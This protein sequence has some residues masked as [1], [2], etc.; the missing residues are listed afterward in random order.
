MF[1]P[2]QLSNPIFASSTLPIVK[3]LSLLFTVF[4]YAITNVFADHKTDS[5]K[6]ALANTKQ[7]TD[8]INILIRIG[9]ELENIN[10][11]TSL[12]LG[13]QALVL[14]QKI[15]WV[16]GIV[17]ALSTMGIFYEIKGD[18]NT[19]LKL[20][21]SAMSMSNK[22]NYT[23]SLNSIYNELGNITSEQNNYSAGLDYYFKALSEDSLAGANMI[24]NICN[25]IG[26]NYEEEG[27]YLKAE[28]YYLKTEKI[29]EEEKNIEHLAITYGNFGNLYYVEGNYKKGLENNFKAM[30]IDS[31]RNNMGGLIPDYQNIGLG[32]MYLQDYPKCIE[33]TFRGLTLSE[34]TGEL[35]YVPK[36]L[37]NIGMVFLEVY[38]AD[39]TLKGFKY[40]RNGKELYIAHSALPDS[41]LVYDENTMITA[42]KINDRLSQLVATKEIGD[43]FVARKD[44]SRAIS[45]YQHAFDLA[46]SLG[47]LQQEMDYSQVLGHTYAQIGNYAMAIKYLNNTIILKDSLFGREK[48]KQ[49]AELEAKYQ[50]EKKEKEIETLAQKNQIQNLQ[51]KQSRSFIF[52]FAFLALLI[53]AFAFLLIRQNRI[54]NWNSKI[55]LEQKLLRSQ[56]NPH[57]IF[58][59][60]TSVQ[61]YIYKEEPQMA[62]NY[63]SS[64][65]KLMRSILESSKEEY[66]LLEKEVETLK[67]YLI[68]QQICFHNKFDFTIDIDPRIN[69]ENTLIPPMMAQPF[70]ENAIVHG[71]VNKM[72]EKGL[73]SIHMTLEND[74]FHFEIE[75]NGVG[76]EKAREIN[77]QRTG[78]HL[79]V[80]INITQDR[81]G[82]LN[83][84]SKKKITMQIIDLK[85]RNNEAT[86]TKVVF[87]FPL[88]T[89][90]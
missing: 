44:F 15:V 3:I 28:E 74:M 87:S 16:K 18:M 64:V 83:K 65:F 54:N 63:L 77:R 4:F 31:S 29:F 25:N 33:Y 68:L 42:K 57:F 67:H 37:G 35:G 32:Y 70:I 49:L 12:L 22:Y 10:P 56:M 26:L 45:Y 21:D 34:K 5:L 71:I 72:D 90:A 8:K 73:I 62:A 61:N 52:G 11:D 47:V 50:N 66:I 17:N 41:A 80:A 79:S 36:A 9:S 24:A 1:E 82:L 84:K 43:V 19:A 86:G 85:D 48:T 23:G 13:K 88:N 14:S 75:D 60:M 6:T 7:D 81:I 40:R 51:I 27:N 78:E 53:A 30:R 39:S 58:N 69:I 55:E 46:D 20:E 59:A 38:Q 76:R 89:L 2:F